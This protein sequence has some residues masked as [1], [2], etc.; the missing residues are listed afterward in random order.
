MGLLRADGVFPGVFAAL[1]RLPLPLLCLQLPHMPHISECLMKR[2][3][4]PTDLRDMTIGQ[5][6]VIVNDLHSQIESKWGDVPGT[7]N[8]MSRG[9]AALWG[10]VLLGGVFPGLAERAHTRDNHR[11]LSVVSFLAIKCQT[12]SDLSKVHRGYRALLNDQ[13]LARDMYLTCLCFWNK[14]LQL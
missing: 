14:L 7:E 2:S 10:S 12:L 1:L 4:K 5:L 8:V 3:L 13:L 11:T 9:E 6:Q